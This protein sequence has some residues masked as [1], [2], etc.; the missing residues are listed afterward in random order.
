MVFMV[1]ARFFTILFFTILRVSLLDL[2]MNYNRL[3]NK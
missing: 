3:N 2:L 1:L